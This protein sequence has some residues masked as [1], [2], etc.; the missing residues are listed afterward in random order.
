M[1]V[2]IEIMEPISKEILNISSLQS[3]ELQFI[4]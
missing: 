1:H 3:S 4:F 2:Y